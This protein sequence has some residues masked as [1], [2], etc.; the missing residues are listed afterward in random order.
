MVPSRTPAASVVPSGL[1]AAD[2]TQSPCPGKH[3]ISRPGSHVSHNR[4]VLS[5]PLD[6]RNLPSEPGRNANEVIAFSS[7]LLSYGLRCIPRTTDSVVGSL[8]LNS[9]TVPSWLPT[10]RIDAPARCAKANAVT[11]PSSP[12][13]TQDSAQPCATFHTRTRPSYPPV[14]KVVASEPKAIH[15]TSFSCPSRMRLGHRVLK[16]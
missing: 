1:K 3:Q 5:R 7:G 13:H 15:E 11:R 2:Q 10:A 12:G 16:T 14:A 8:R 6:A 9:L 4:T